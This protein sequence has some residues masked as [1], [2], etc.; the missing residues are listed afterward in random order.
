MLPATFLP[1]AE[2]S[3]LIV[4]IGNWVLHAACQQAEVWRRAGITV[5]V[6]V[7]ISARELTELDLAERV[8]E[9]LAYCRLPG[10]AL[11]L[12]ISEEAVLRDPER[13]RSALKDL[14]RLGVLIALDKFGIGQLSLGLPSGLPLDVVKLDR[15]LT[16]SFH[17]DK[18]RRAMF[19]ATIALAKEAGLT[20]VAVGIETNRQL[21]L[22]RELD[23]TVGQ[24]FLLHGPASADRV[25]LRGSFASTTPA[26][27]RP[28]V[29]LR[30]AGGSN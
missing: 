8:R 29:R 11:C 22:A 9:E 12:E 3:E 10:R 6:S 28:I 14:K 24:G 18:D 17:Q 20:A 16:N 5:P 23:C 1:P 4:Q 19:A 30:G 26:P 25:R 2:D 13:A 21:A 7:N 15:A 27:W